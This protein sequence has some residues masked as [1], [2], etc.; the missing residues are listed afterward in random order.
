VT[1]SRDTRRELIVAYLLGELE[2][3][4]SAALESRLASDSALRDEL[5]SLRPIVGE[6]EQLPGSAWE[7]TDPPP[8]E[9][10]PPPDRPREAPEQSTRRRARW[11]RPQLAIVG[12]AVVAALAAGVGIGALIERDEQ[13]PATT[14]RSIPLR[15]LGQTAPGA[16]GEVVVGPGD[17]ADLRVSDLPSNG[18]DFYEIW[19][20]GDDGLVS[21][22]SFRV[23]PDGAA[24]VRLA[25]PVNPKAYQSFDV[26]LEP[27]DGNP[28]H[29][30]DS[31]LRGPA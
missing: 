25:L 8:L 16:K 10:P 17:Q 19:L 15:T 23:G 21:L 2:A 1:D 7:G 6:L 20:L 26:S 28:G 5:E 11:T 30:G 18:R 27:D 31:V 9:L 4:E 3:S 14:G 13:T 29:S 12:L 22:G 24:N